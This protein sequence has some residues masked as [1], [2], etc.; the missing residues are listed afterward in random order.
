MLLFVWPFQYITISC[1]D[2]CVLAFA[3]DSFEI[4]TKGSNFHDAVDRTRVAEPKLAI[5]VVSPSIDIIFVVYHY[6]MIVATTHHP[7]MELASTA[8]YLRFIVLLEI[9]YSSSKLMHIIRAP[10]VDA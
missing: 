4:F 6:C 9:L 3:L 2:K 5:L 10:V 1:H 8:T 7:R